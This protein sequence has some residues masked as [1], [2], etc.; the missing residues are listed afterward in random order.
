MPTGRLAPATVGDVS[1]VTSEPVELDDL[2]SVAP[3]LA[4]ES[5]DLWDTVRQDMR[6]TADVVN[7]PIRETRS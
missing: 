5:A 6:C 7:P 2:E 4:W 1:V 3:D